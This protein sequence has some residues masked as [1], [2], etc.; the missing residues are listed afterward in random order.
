MSKEKSKSG[1]SRDELIIKA[2]KMTLT[3]VIKD[4][5]VQPGMRHPL[6]DETIDGIRKC[7]FLLSE[8]EKE[9]AELAGRPNLERPHYIDEPKSSVVVQLDTSELKKKRASEPDDEAS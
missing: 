2:M 7:L 6:S 5:T 9:L 8:R 3:D 4:T 1:L